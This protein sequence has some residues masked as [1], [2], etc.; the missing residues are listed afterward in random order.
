[1]Y[2]V[3]ANFVFTYNLSMS[4]VPEFETGALIWPLVFSRI[5]VALM[6]SIITMVGLLILMEAYVEAG[7]LLPLIFVVWFF[8]NSITNR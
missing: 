7:V 3:F 4:W 6:L 8:M 2:F 5:K 1:M